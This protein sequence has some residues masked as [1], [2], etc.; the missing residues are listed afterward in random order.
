MYKSIILIIT[1][2]VCFG[3][4]SVGEYNS[5][6]I[7]SIHIDTLLFDNASIRAISFSKDTVFYAANKN[8]IGYVTLDKSKKYECIVDNSNPSLEFRSIAITSQYVFVLSIENPAFL[9]RFTKDLKDFKLVYQEENPKIFY[10]SMC[11]WND[12]EGIAIGDPISDCLSVITTRDGGT[13]WQKVSCT[14]LPKIVDGEAAFAASNT[15]ICIKGNRTWIV[16]G[17][18][19]ARVFFS[20]NKGISWKTYE[21]PIVQGKTM[22]GIFTSDF[23]NEKTG[24]IAGGDYENS[25]QN[26]KNKAITNN[27]GK[28]W[29]L[30]AENAGFGYAYCVQF[31]PNSNGNELVSVGATGIHYSSNRGVSWT[32]LSTDNSLYSIRL[33]SSSTAIASGKNK[34]IKINFKRKS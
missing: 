9:Y 12:N 11:F 27:G 19:K 13:S 26:F 16:S 15:N 4:K 30:I 25:I 10:D 6:E 32:Q 1:S 20:K 7:S 28:S 18:K 22:T 33:I 17:G 5:N 2:I 31:I 21:T 8:K 29:E 24:I 3:C 14:Q 34:I 23:Y